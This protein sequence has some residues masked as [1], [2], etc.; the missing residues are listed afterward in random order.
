MAT[1]S[2]TRSPRTT[3]SGWGLTIQARGKSSIPWLATFHPGSMAWSCGT[4]STDRS[5]GMSN[6]T[7]A[8][9]VAAL[10]NAAAA[11]YAQGRLEAAADL[12]RQAAAA[13]PRD[14]R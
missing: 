6:A 7:Q 2:P 11:C 3:R 12:Y 9:D 1:T 14:P 5:R 8:Q 13:D 4:A 10:L